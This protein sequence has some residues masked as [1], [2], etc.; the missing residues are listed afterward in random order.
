MV[1][2]MPTHLFIILAKVI[3]HKSLL[4]IISTFI[5]QRAPI[6]TGISSMT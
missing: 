2:C 6:S 5:I 4:L 3:S 1:I